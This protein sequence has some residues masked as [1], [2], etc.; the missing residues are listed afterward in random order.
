MRV[1]TVFLTLLLSWQI[2]SAQEPT[3]NKSDAKIYKKIDVFSKDRKFFKFIHKLIFRS[4]ESELAPVVTTKKKV[5]GIAET[6]KLYSSYQCKIIRNIKI[7]TLDPFGY[8]IDN[9][10]YSPNNFFE[11]AGNTIH[12]KTKNWTIRNLLLFKKNQE[13]DSLLVKESER[14]IRN[15][16]FSNNVIIRPIAIENNI[17]S[18]DVYVRVLDTWSL[19]PT[20]SYAKAKAN[21]DITERNFLGL[22]HQFEIDTKKRFTDNT[23]GY[24]TKYSINNF[25]LICARS[26][27]LKDPG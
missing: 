6:Q 23:N 15:Q 17:D 16:R 14:I 26:V 21:L 18:V 8:S 24:M 9:E 1:Y 13:L 3:S 4:V 12:I 22:G 19:I 11:K 10:S 25:V 27:L 5:R 20:G 2:S 7:E